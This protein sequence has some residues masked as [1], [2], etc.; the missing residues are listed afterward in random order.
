MK[1]RVIVFIVIALM[2]AVVN[3]GEEHPVLKTL[4][5]VEQ[6][7]KTSVKDW[8]YSVD[9]QKW[10]MYSPGTYLHID[11]FQLKTNIQGINIF[12]GNKVSGTPLQ[13]KLKLV[14]RGLSKIIVLVNGTEIEKFEINGAN[15]QYAELEK[16]ILLAQS[17]EIKSYEVALAVENTGLEPKRSQIWP[18]RTKPL[19]EEYLEFTLQSADFNYLAVQADYQQLSQWHLS[20][21]TAY[22]LINPEPVRYT[23]TKKPYQ[24][25]DKRG[26]SSKLLT[27]LNEELAKAVSILDQ[28][29]LQNGDSVKLRQSIEKSYQSAKKIIQYAH[30]FHV[31]LIG[32][33]HIDIAWLWRIA[34]TVMVARNTYETVIKNMAEYPEL[35]YAQSQAVTY[36]WIEQ[37]YPGLF[38]EIQKKVKEG[39]WEIVGGMWVEPDCNLIA[40]ESWVR[41]ILFGKNYFKNKF[42]VDVTIGWNP[43]SFGYNWNMPQIYKKS[44]IDAFITQKLWWNDTTVFP[45]FMFWW[46]GADDTKIFTYLP[47][48]SYDSDLKMKDVITGITR[49]QL[50]TGLKNS[51]ILF[52]MGD[53]GGGPNREILNRVKDYSTLK[54]T[55]TYIHGKASD[56]LSSFLKDTKSNLPVWN[57]ELYLEYH[58]GTFTTQAAIKKNNRRSESMMSAAEKIA[59]MA[60]LLGNPYP[61]ERL[62]DAWKII[63]TNQFHDILPGS[64]ITPVYRDAIEQHQKA[65]KIITAV[66]NTALDAM[67]AQINTSK[68]EGIPIVVF[69]TL[70]W[71]RKDVATINNPYPTEEKVKI[72]DDT[73]AEVPCEVEKDEDPG[74]SKITFIAEKIPSLGYRVYSVTRGEPSQITTELKSDNNAI[75]NAYYHIEIDQNSGNIKSIFDKKLKR[76]FVAPGKQ[77]NILWV[78][79]DRPQD[80]DAWN[81]GYTGR[82]WELN[83]ADAIELV[84]I[85]PVKAVFQVKKSFLGFS[86]DR[87]SPT[88]DFPSSFFTQ[89]IILY[90]GLDRI[91][92]K[93]EA[94]WWEDH[95]SLKAVFPVDV[96]SEK[97]TFEIPF[98]AIKRTTRFESLWEKARYEVPALKW[99]DLSDG[100]VGISLLNDSKYGYDVHGNI[101]KLSLLR[102]PTW[103]DPMADRGKHV[104]TYSLYTHKG[105][106][107][108]ADTVKRGYE[109]NTPLITMQTEKH[110]GPQPSTASFCSLD[111]KGVILDTVKKAESGNALVF[112]LYES[113]GMLAKIALI[114]FKTPKKIIETNL[115]ENDIKELPV[116]GNRLDL[117]FKKFE[118]R[119]FKIFFE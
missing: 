36:R 53:H 12:A 37:K 83:E 31:T 84:G 80:W 35:H 103:P 88:E 51:L 15:G 115:L 23:F 54:I 2:I 55:P 6:S 34:E 75:E 71:E 40:G 102:S 101:M 119:T 104:F 100:K 5:Q 25:P 47:P 65:Q 110:D 76:E 89:Y 79:E 7:I 107:N 94:D 91:D 59:S 17:S 60:S 67:L 26:L 21:K 61:V 10:E 93:T 112:R 16:E 30:D 57:D 113:N 22:T 29:A 27:A 77:A 117:D 81:I 82:G 4:D 109:L 50:T 52:G 97:A 24:I 98:A 74:A 96:I 66:Q 19:P 14:S 114:F 11:K 64:S 111:G 108:D 33:A 3:A 72:V 105:D 8:S 48:L 32:N 92:I 85:S 41:Q 20:F 63:L 73:G 49:Y 99:A 39:R 62:S 18:E 69:N 1:Q 28:N 95:L 68:V 45:H 58:Q 106:F 78:Y 38:S 44:G 87:Y 42:G 118:I 9:G 90:R 56:F 70:S 86:K 46:Q 43:D 13:V 116:T